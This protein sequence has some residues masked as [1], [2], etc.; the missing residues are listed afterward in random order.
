MIYLMKK[1]LKYNLLLEDFLL[2]KKYLDILLLQYII[3]HFVIKY[4]IYFVG[5]LELK[6][7]KYLKINY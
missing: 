3:N 2:G 5:M 7:F 4:R 1:Q 6:F